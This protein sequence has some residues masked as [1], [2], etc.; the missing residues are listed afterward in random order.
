MYLKLNKQEIDAIDEML[1]GVNPEG[2]IIINFGW[3]K[4]QMFYVF[5]ELFIDIE[6][7]KITAFALCNSELRDSVAV[8]NIRDLQW[9]KKHELI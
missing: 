3:G 8:E 7:G 4:A 2:E 1:K 9:V 5:D 6:K